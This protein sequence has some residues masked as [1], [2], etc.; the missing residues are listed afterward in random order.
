[1]IIRLKSM[2][3]LTVF[4]MLAIMLSGCRSSQL[5]R[6]KSTVLPDVRPQE[7]VYTTPVEEWQPTTVSIASQTHPKTLTWAEAKRQ[8]L[9]AL[10]RDSLL[11][12]SQLGLSVYDLSENQYIIQVN[13]DQR[14]RPASCQKV[15]TS[16]SALH[17]LGGEYL[18]RTQLCTTGEVKA[19][20][21]LTGDVYVI[22]GM[23]PMLS[24]ADL[25]E[26]AK[27]LQTMGVKRIAGKMY[28]D[29]SAKDSN[30]LG[31]GWCWDDDY[32]PLT[33][34][35]VDKKDTFSEEWFDALK[36]CKIT[37]PANAR[38]QAEK[39]SID[40]VLALPTNGCLGRAVCPASAHLVMEV[41]HTIDQLLEKMMKDSDNIY[42]ES[43]FYQLAFHTGEKQAG[44]KQA[45]RL[46]NALI[47]SLGLHADDYQIADGSGL[48]LYD[49]VSPTLLVTLLRYA[50]GEK[51]IIGHL[52]SSLPVASVD[53]TLE[54]RMHGTP[55]SEHIYAKT[56]TVN[57]ISS[58]SGYAKASNG[59]TLCFSIINQ[60]VSKGSL[61]RAFQ[62]KVCEVLCR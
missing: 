1:M 23:D 19:N 20:G 59:H 44:R 30:P 6:H 58:L 52:W 55:A 31:W 36:T 33:A 42:A 54:K 37:V 61:G 56:G 16:I 49:Y 3:K 2:Q 38:T 40:G 12:R 29:L 43:L 15:V 41:T 60:G 27:A 50:Y 51:E 14:M 17:Y 39:V 10:L 46:I 13:A 53:G 62:D 35:T 34:L 21:D 26:M 7:S 24:K 4:A 28:V 11:E 25:R 57:G 45:V 8:Q 9:E 48:S 22:G 18:L 32:G 5:M 47:E